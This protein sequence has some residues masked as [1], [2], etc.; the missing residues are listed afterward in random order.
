MPDLSPCPLNYCTIREPHEHRYLSQGLFGPN[1]HQEELRVERAERTGGFERVK[2]ELVTV[3]CRCPECHSTFDGLAF[4]PLK[5]GEVAR[6]RI[7]EVCAERMQPTRP[8]AAVKK[9]TPELRP[10]ERTGTDE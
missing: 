6:A 7:C 4:T 9:P 2:V 3:R 10:P 8:A 1:V 5:E